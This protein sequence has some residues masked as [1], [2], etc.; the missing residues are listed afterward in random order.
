MLH[1]TVSLSSRYMLF[2]TEL[3]LGLGR[4]LSLKQF[5][6]SLQLLCSNSSLLSTRQSIQWLPE[7]HSHHVSPQ[8][9]CPRRDIPCDGNTWT[10]KW[11]RGSGHLS[12]PARE[13]QTSKRS[14]CDCCQHVVKKFPET[15]TSRLESHL[16]TLAGWDSS[17][18]FP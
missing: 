5:Q 1:V 17:G 11:D 12:G 3:G 7:P 10:Q 14:E 6:P 4:S 2:G 8:K 9:C 18:V 13:K 15:V 16:E